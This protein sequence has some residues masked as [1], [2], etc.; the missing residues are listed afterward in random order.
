MCAYSVVDLF[1]GAGGLSLGFEQTGSYNIKLAYEKNPTMRQTYKLNH[2]GTVIEGDIRQADYDKILENFGAIDV[3]IGG[4]PCQGFS[5]ANRQKN[6]M[7]NQNNILVKEYIK[8]IVRLRPKAFLMENV[9]MLASNTH[10]F[11]VTA[12]DLVNIEKFE[13]D[14][15]DE[16]ITLLDCEFNFDGAERFIGNINLINQYLL[17]D[18]YYSVLKLLDKHKKNATRLE[19]AWKKYKRVI[20]LFCK[21]YEEAD[22]DLLVSRLNRE[23]SRLLQTF[24]NQDKIDL[25]QQQLQNG[26]LTQTL[27]VQQ[28]LRLCHEIYDNRIEVEAVQ[29]EGDLSITVKTVTVIE[30]LTKI[31]GSKLYGYAFDQGILSAADFGAPQKRERYFF[32]GVQKNLCKN[33]KLPQG[34]ITKEHYR[35]VRD[36]I[37]DLETISPI[38]DIS[39]DNGIALPP[40]EAP[41]VL[42]NV[43]RDSPVLKNH[44][45]TNTRTTSM[46]R[47]KLIKQGENFHDLPEKFKTNTYSDISRTQNTIYQRLAYDSPSGTVVNVRKSMWI[48]PTLNRAISVREAARLQTFPDSFV[49]AGTK[50]EQYQQVGNAVPPILAKALALKIRDVLDGKC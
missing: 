15:N 27:Q 31:L 20:E 16:T 9:S 13:I 17:S 4:P 50:D 3:V 6:Q 41:G 19:N 42:R 8:A 36:A 49:F 45:I 39:K 10:K 38:V 40:I 29:A 37:E 33:V 7:I 28:M 26:A 18:K 22:D 2:N 5:N 25:L 30:Y 48:H 32:L 1:S 12:E 23:T 21:E 46:E 11:F 47:F 43:L 14:S 34:K 35:T 44:I 24:Y